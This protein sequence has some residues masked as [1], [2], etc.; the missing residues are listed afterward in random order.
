MAK[1]LAAKAAILAEDDEGF[2]LDQ[3]NADLKITKVLTL[4][5]F[6]TAK[7]LTQSKV[8][9]HRKRVNVITKPPEHSYAHDVV[10]NPSYACL[11]PGSGRVLSV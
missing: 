1:V 8:K 9:N 3:V 10:T 7:V 11:K 5:P 2:T 6:E 4:A